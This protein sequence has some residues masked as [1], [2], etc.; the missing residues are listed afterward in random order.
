ME[1][2]LLIGASAVGLG[3]FGVVVGLSRSVR[4]TEGGD[5][6]DAITD[7]APDLHRAELDRPLVERLLGPA[8]QRFERAVRAVTPSWWITRIRANAK[9]AG[10]RA[11]GPDS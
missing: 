5:I 7:D 8:M 3:I 10:F 2:T 11:W 4:A 1:P 9:L 6:L